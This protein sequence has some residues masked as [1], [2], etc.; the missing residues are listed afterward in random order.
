MTNFDDVSDRPQDIRT[1]L[2]AELDSLRAKSNRS[3]WR[4]KGKE[5][6]IDP[7]HEDWDAYREAKAHLEALREY[8]GF[9]EA[10]ATLTAPARTTRFEYTETEDGWIDRF[11]EL[12]DRHG[13]IP[14]KEAAKF[15]MG[16]IRALMK[17]FPSAF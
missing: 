2:E 13:Q 1:S 7:T 12:T 8:D 17:A 6:H 15:S 16:E 14:E 4:R 3:E 9:E 11:C 5:V 10:N